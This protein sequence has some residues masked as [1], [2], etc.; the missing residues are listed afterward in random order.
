MNPQMIEQLARQR[1]TEVRQA[2][3]RSRLAAVPR[4][5]QETI[6]QRA[7]STLI[8]AGLRGK[9]AARRQHAAARP[10]GL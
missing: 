1:L 3:D 2:A 7:G 4:V 8:R 9:A 6:G 5:Q 10:V